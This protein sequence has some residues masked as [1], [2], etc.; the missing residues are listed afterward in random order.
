MPL[1]LLMMRALSSTSTEHALAYF[2]GGTIATLIVVGFRAHVGFFLVMTSEG[3]IS[4]IYKISIP[5]SNK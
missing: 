2:F 3:S 4:A 5:M 1:F